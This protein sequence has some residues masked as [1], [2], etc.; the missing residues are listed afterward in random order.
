MIDINR[1]EIERYLGYHGNRPDAQV[2][3]KIDDCI[4][5]LNIAANPSSTYKES[6]QQ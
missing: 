4:D 6:F 5:Q 1:S 2:D 3:K